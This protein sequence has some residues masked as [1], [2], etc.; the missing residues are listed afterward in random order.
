MFGNP[1]KIIVYK[2]YCNK[3]SYLF[4]ASSVGAAGIPGFFL[5]AILM[6][7]FGRR[8]AHALV[9]LPG[10]VGWLLIYFASDIPTIMTGRILGGI[11]AGATVSL[12][13]IAIGEYSSP[14]YRGMFLNL[15]TASVSFGGMVIH[16]LANY[17]TW[18]NIALVAIFPHIVAILIVLTWPESPAWLAS[19]QQFKKCEDSF[20]WLRG[21]SAESNRE[22]EELI[23]AQMERS[24][25]R[26]VLTFSE[27]LVEFLKKFTRKDFM[28]PLIICIF[29]ALLLEACGRHIFPAY[30]MLIIGEI[31][32][33]SSYSFY[34]TLCLDL[35]IVISSL[36]SSILVR[37]TKRRTL[38]FS[39]GFAAFSV[40][41]IVCLYLFLAS[42]SIISK[43]HKFPI[44]LFVVYFIL[45][46]LGCT[47]IPMALLGEVYPLAHR[48]AGSAVTGIVMSL[49]VM[50]GLQL[51]PILLFNLKVYGTFAVYGAIMG[52]SLLILYFLLPETK[53]KTL[54]EIED[55]FNYGSFKKR[56]DYDVEEKSKMVL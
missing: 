28:K 53:D 33:N 36:S 17:M 31:T 12:G 54:Q 42:R 27:K 1:S 3:I 47:P 16:I 43:D 32:G 35:I 14:I 26:K 48:A 40:L 19:R 18:R 49:C 5:S 55:Y 56:G 52:L 37:L 25:F 4:S 9:I 2:K 44:A 6:D 7:M 23:N 15:K 46:N 41:M 30:A 20:Y 10:T 51:T 11:T 13:A 34:Y 21:N 45:A 29:G 38:L 39:T 22:L 8:I 50:F 24:R